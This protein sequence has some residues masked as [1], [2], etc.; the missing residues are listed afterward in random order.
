MPRFKEGQLVI[1]VRG[2][3]QAH[4]KEGEYYKLHSVNNSDTSVN[5]AHPN[6]PK[7]WGGWDSDRFRP[8]TGKPVE[9]KP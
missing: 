4:L 5:I 2:Y 3:P 8:A 1:C 7:G 9:D 6:F